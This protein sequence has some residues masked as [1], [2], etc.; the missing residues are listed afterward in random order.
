MKTPV[1]VHHKSAGALKNSS[2]FKDVD[3][4]CLSFSFFSLF[5]YFTEHHLGIVTRKWGMF[6]GT[7]YV[8][9]NVHAYVV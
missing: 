8:Y 2:V 4:G 3:F 9:G 1:S 5:M 6:V 7:E